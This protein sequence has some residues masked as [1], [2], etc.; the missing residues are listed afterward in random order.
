M[1]DLLRFATAGSVE[2]IVA[3]A[4]DKRVV[5]EEAAK[6][7]VPV[8]ALGV[9]R[10][11]AA[12]DDRVVPGTAKD[13]DARRLREECR[14]DRRQIDDVIARAADDLNLTH[15][16]GESAQ[17]GN[18]DSVLEHFDPAGLGLAGSQFQLRRG[19]LC[20]RQQAIYET[21]YRG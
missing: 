8:T 21:A 7:V 4:A 6:R 14:S 15:L 17:S 16:T 18:Q 9:R 19:C 1:S 2:R 13:A 12:A 20:H 5:A 11:P 3:R 10:E